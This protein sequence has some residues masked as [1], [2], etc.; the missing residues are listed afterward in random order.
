MGLVSALFSFG[1]G[2]AWFGF[3]F[4]P[5][6]VSVSRSGWA[7]TARSKPIFK[8]LVQTKFAWEGSISIGE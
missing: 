8:K 1:L 6:S 4:G 2:L 3:G 5:V 7:E